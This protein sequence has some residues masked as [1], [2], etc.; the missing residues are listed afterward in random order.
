ML[1]DTVEAASRSL[2]D[3]S[4]STISELVDRLF[5]DKMSELV[6]SDIT[7]REVGTVRHTFKEY[8]MQIYHARI[9]YPKRK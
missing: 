5:E 1:A 9:A 2:K 6:E 3:Y 4:E 8:L 7:L